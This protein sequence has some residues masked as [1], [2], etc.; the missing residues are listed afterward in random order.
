MRK[1]LA[2]PNRSHSESE[3]RYV[4]SG[5]EVERRHARGDSGRE[6]VDRRV[7]LD[8]PPRSKLKKAVAKGAAK[9]ATRRRYT[10][11]IGLRELMGVLAI[12]GPLGTFVSLWVLPESGQSGMNV[13]LRR[14]A[15]GL[16]ER[17][18]VIHLTLAG[19]ERKARFVL[20][21]DVAWEEF[22]TGV[23]ERL[24]LGS[25]NRIETS[26]GEAIMSVE[27]LM[28]D[29]HLIIY[30][31][32]ALP[33]TARSNSRIR[34]RSE[35][36]D[37][38]ENTADPD[39]KN[40]ASSASSLSTATS[41]LES[42]RSGRR[43]RGAAINS[44]LRSAELLLEEAAGVEGQPAASYPGEGD[45]SNAAVSGGGD[46]FVGEGTAE[47][48][49]AA[50]AAAEAEKAA[51]KA[52]AAREAAEAARAA[53]EAAHATELADVRE[54]AKQAHLLFRDQHGVS[55]QA[56]SSMIST[57]SESFQ[58]TPGLGWQ[59]IGSEL[60]WCPLRMPQWR[61]AMVI[62]WVGTLPLW[63]SY[64]F[65]SAAAASPL[66]DFLVFHEGQ[67]QL[68]PIDAPPNVIFTDL[69]P[70]GL[71]QLFGM[72]LGEALDLPIRN[73]TIV[74][75]AMRLM[76][77]KW[78]RLI[79][80]Y[81]PT[82]GSVF[83]SYLTSYTHWGYCDL[84]MVIG[85]L[86]LFIEPAELDSYDVVSYSFG[87]QEAL[88]LRGQ[89]TM[90]RNRHHVNTMW[91]GCLH[92]GHGL[93]KEL[94]LKVAWVRRMEARGL[95]NYPKRFQS[96]EGCY[97]QR[98]VATRG[99]RIRVAH[100]QFVG[101]T[102]PADQVIYS[103]SSSVWQCPRDAVVDVEEL[104]RH[105][106]RGRCQVA[107]PDLPVQPNAVQRLHGGLKPISL[108]TEGCGQWM[109]AEYRMCARELLE[110]GAEVAAATALV[111]AND[112]LMVQ[113]YTPSPNY[114]LENGCRQGA[115]F[116]FQEWKKAWA[117]PGG[118]GPLMGVESVGEPPRY[119]AQPRNFTLTPEGIALIR[120]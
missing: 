34:H 12:L 116:H 10:C 29:D 15:P 8:L 61:I 30:S 85:N 89:W 4:F 96:A 87:D 71:A 62:P 57:T 81:K 109:P 104:A 53:A 35:A 59:G 21:R 79:A 84:D 73:T 20:A 102:V 112:S 51:V 47:E 6:G 100:K 110:A 75:K 52:A 24:R 118:V 115:F 60:R 23:Q 58:S 26:A 94:L 49:A 16:T 32:N 80:E 56:P 119:S 111:Y 64:F 108:T 28:H 19:L 86:P 70:G 103:V 88:Y 11:A 36:G 63:S 43:R 41:L 31:D 76:F 107:L 120:M 106:A 93:Q 13:H 39:G 69:G 14:S 22:L 67:K 98:A 105:S 117:G 83:A 3:R 74:I 77:E 5:S 92:L 44:T 65:S 25:I 95:Q 7:P 114:A 97:S 91:K 82:F 18:R 9:T 46:Q 37:G 2:T 17:A 27:D 90:H 68:Q 72:S 42:F 50:A 54:R 66:V 48:A 113:R 78:P 40:G 99:I 101:L 1:Q 55:M 38:D 33:V 45:E